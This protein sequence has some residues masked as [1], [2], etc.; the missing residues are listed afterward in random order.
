MF[1][2]QAPQFP[3]FYSW[4]DIQRKAE[5]ATI[6]TIDFN[7]VLVDH[8]IAYFD[9]VTENTFTTYTKK[10]VNLNK[11]IAEDAKKIIKSEIKETKA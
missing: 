7:K 4:N 10:V 6:K 1:F 9:S 11:N 8:T 5:D 2:T 3:T